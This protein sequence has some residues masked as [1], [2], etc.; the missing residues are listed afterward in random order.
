MILLALLVSCVIFILYLLMY[1][2]IKNYH[3]RFLFNK[4][5]ESHL[6]H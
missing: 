1:N 2:K 6:N 3:A 5:I 4:V